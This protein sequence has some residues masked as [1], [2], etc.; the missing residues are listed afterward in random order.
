MF[1]S[2]CLQVGSKVVRWLVEEMEGSSKMSWKRE[3][4]K[5]DSYFMVIL[6]YVKNHQKAIM[7][8]KGNKIN[9]YFIILVILK[10]YFFNWYKVN[11]RIFLGNFIQFEYSKVNL[12]VLLKA[13]IQYFSFPG[14]KSIKI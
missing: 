3:I 14:K 10:K 7:I 13:S 11:Y 12:I 1:F 4:K 5:N 6:N 2:V 9:H 8:S